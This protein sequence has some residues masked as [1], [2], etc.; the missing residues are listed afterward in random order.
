M[1]AEV[2]ASRIRQNPDIRG[3]QVAGTEKKVGGY[4]DDT[5]VFVSSVKSVGHLLSEFCL[6]GRA[7]GSRLNQDK[8]EGLWLGRWRH[9]PDKPYGFTWKSTRL[10]VLGVWIGD[11]TT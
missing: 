8:T 5:Q 4:A 3:I 11:G 7:S 9:R 6:Y 10:K 2:L 1:V